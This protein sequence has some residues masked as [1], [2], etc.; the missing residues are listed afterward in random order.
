MRRA[1]LA[2]FAAQFA[3][4]DLVLRRPSA[5]DFVPSALVS[6]AVWLLVASAAR[7]RAARVSIAL[8]AALL[9][10]APIVFYRHY[11]VFLDDDA[12]GAARHMWGDVRPTVVAILPAVLAATALAA[13]AEY[14]LLARTEPAP[15]RVRFGALA[16]GLLAIPFLPAL[17]NAS[18]DLAAAGSLRALFRTPSA[19][20]AADVQVPVLRSRRARLPNVLF[21][22]DESVRASDYDAATAP[23]TTA[24]TAGRVDLHEMRSVASYTSIAVASL[25]SSLSPTTPE[26]VLHDA[27]YLFDF[28]RA[29]RR[30]DQRVRVAYLSSQTDS[31]FEHRDVR[32]STDVYVT[33]QDLV[34]RPVGDIEDVID[35]GVDGLLADRVERELPKLEKPFFAMVHLSGTHA[36]Y[37]VDDARAPFRPYTHAVTWAGLGEL[38][39]AYRDAI[40][41]Q[42]AAVA[43]V[44]RAFFAATEGEPALVVFTSDHGEAF[45]E[46]AAIHHG[47]SLYDEQ[48]HVPA[49]VLPRG[50]ALDDLQTQALVAHAGDFVTHLDL[51]PT[52]LDAYGVLDD[53]AMTP[54]AS[55]FGGRSLLRTGEPRTIAL[56]NCTDMF[57]C[58]VRT[59][60]LTRGDRTLTAQSWDD[61]WRCVDLRS[62]QLT[63]DASCDALRESS[64]AVFPTLPNGRANR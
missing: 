38:H 13:I 27:P 54:F 55:R 19:R 32:A 10:V 36:P 52:V 17:R 47:Q 26:D 15:R 41:A 39:A 29:I 35:L 21:I 42:D 44:V 16:I 43:R 18:Q 12:I 24:L 40:V 8:L 11:H 22:L 57:P 7:R 3:I 58:P 34:H 37:F 61:G 49:W 6:I 31:L 25:L 2:L 20:A 64:R 48:I 14:A 63:N 23:E 53:F 60:G 30:D 5:R 50:G 45:G 51:V 56:T 28:L 1:A 46:H 62:E 4:V 59:W 9:L 33:V